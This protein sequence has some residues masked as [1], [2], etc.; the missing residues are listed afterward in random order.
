VGSYPYWPGYIETLDA[1]VDPKTRGTLLRGRKKKGLETAELVIFYQS[2]DLSWVKPDKLRPF[3]SPTAGLIPPPDAGKSRTPDLLQA[4]Q[5]AEADLDNR[6]VVDGQVSPPKATTK[7]LSPPNKRPKLD[8]EQPKR[9]KPKPIAAPVHQALVSLW[10][11]LYG[12][13]G[14][15]HAAL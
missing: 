5:E 13:Y 7:V 11:A 8:E 10:S 2:S 3:H 6:S 15:A 12:V 1:V 4:I 14:T 9:K